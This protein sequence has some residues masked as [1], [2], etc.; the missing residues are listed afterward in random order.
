LRAGDIA[1]TDFSLTAKTWG[2]LGFVALTG[3]AFSIILLVLSVK[4]RDGFAL[5]ATLMLSFLSTLVGISGKWHLN[6]QKRMNNGRYAPPADVVIR[7]LKGSFLV[8]SCDEDVARELYFAPEIINYNVKSQWAYRIISLVGTI[9]LMFGVIFLANSST[10][11]QLCFAGA[12]IIMNALYWVIAALPNRVHWDTSCFKVSDQAIEVRP[13]VPVTNKAAENGLGETK[14]PESVPP[15]KFRGK[16]TKFV[17]S[18]KT[19]TWALWKAILVTQSIDWVKANDAAPDTPAWK[20]WLAEAK[21]RALSLG[22]DSVY[23]HM[24]E[25]DKE[26]TL[27]YRLPD[28]NPQLYL[29]ECLERHKTDLER[30]E[31]Q[32][33]RAATIAAIEMEN[34]G[35]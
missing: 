22:G 8:V 19:F 6:L 14:L 26:R 32:P 21:T 11:M 17:D 28:W 24:F 25:G 35:C 4:K 1:T 34:E 13:E 20:D 12:F 15:K 5:L 30:G 27:V 23:S 3:T 18:N 2:P 9:Q 29:Q 7:Y 31:P 10:W 16:N 33:N